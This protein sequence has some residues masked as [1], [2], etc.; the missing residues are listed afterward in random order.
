MAAP[1]PEATALLAT[2]DAGRRVLLESRALFVLRVRVPPPPED[3]SFSWTVQ[4]NAG[5]DAVWY[6]DGSLYD[7]P[8]QYA[9]RVGFGIVVTTAG[10][11]LLG[12]GGGTPPGWVHDS[13]GAE[14][15]ALFQS[16]R[17]CP[18]MPNVVTDCLGI[19]ETMKRGVAAA[20]D[21][22]RP[23]AR[24]WRLVAG[25]LDGAFD[26][27]SHSLV[28]MPSHGSRASVGAAQK[29]NHTPVS[30]LDW[31]AN[32]LVDQVAK[33]AA[34]GS[35]VT[36]VCKQVDA[37][38]SG[39]RFLAARVGVAT[40][41]SNHC[42]VLGELRRDAYASR[43]HKKRADAGGTHVSSTGGPEVSLACLGDSPARRPG[44]A[45][46]V[47]VSLDQPTHTASSRATATALH[48]DRMRTQ[49]TELIEHWRGSLVLGPASGA[50]THVK[51]QEMLER[52][53][54]KQLRGRIGDS[55][56]RHTDD[57][58]RTPAASS[59]GD[60]NVLVPGSYT[61]CVSPCRF[62]ASEGDPPNHLPS[63]AASPAMARRRGRSS[64]SSAGARHARH[65]VRRTAQP[66][67]GRGRTR[68][69]P[70]P[71]AQAEGVVARSS[72][73]LAHTEGT[74]R[75]SLVVM[76]AALEGT[77]RRHSRGASSPRAARLTSVGDA[78][79][80]GSRRR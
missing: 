79:V 62:F 16:V 57:Q 71:L 75:N 78:S 76:A 55:A 9:R 49:S 10:G 80:A 69:Y 6:I 50:P 19:L 20:T 37:A 14:L 13:A 58:D 28:W 11:E 32:R 29:S 22:K 47:V 26:T 4:P 2:L 56:E 44:I 18:F 42:G 24:L 64:S 31:R 77:M 39:F 67:R 59:V 3:E 7:Q 66:S 36:A 68:S 23:L 61:H 21:A 54:G 35:R 17:L 41:R 15:W 65:R 12:Y 48:R 60:D 63:S 38:A 46:T 52:I 30:E 25:C 5:D 74:F 53:R 33:A 43:C 34:G 73:A 70:D 40:Y 72:L 45:P 8:R 51:R 1:P 27:A